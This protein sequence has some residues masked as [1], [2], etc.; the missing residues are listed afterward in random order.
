MFDPEAGL[1]HAA[2]TLA[3]THQCSNLGSLKASATM[4]ERRFL[5]PSLLL[6]LC[7]HCRCVGPVSCLEK[8]DG[9]RKDHRC[10]GLVVSLD[11]HLRRLETVYCGMGA[12]SL[13]C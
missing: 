1:S 6:G 5:Y 8:T 9:S 11:F 12:K 13:T 10:F 7:A 3:T 2:T 4:T